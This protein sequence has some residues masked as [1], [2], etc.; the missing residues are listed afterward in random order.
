VTLLDTASGDSAN[1]VNPI[2]VGNIGGGSGGV[3]FDGAG[4]LY[5][6]NGYQ[7]AGPSPTGAIKV[8]ENASWWAALSGGPPADFEA[9]G[10][11]VAELLSAGS[12]GFDA[13]GNLHVGGG[14]SA[15]GDVDYIGLIRAQVVSNALAGGGPA[16][17][18]DPEQV[19]RFDPDAAGTNFYDAGYNRVRNELYV[20]DGATV[21]VYAVPEPGSLVLL[22]LGGLLGWRR[23]CP[24]PRSEP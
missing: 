17:P 13:E 20:R 15:A 8:F 7:L 4:N 11:G 3:A 22:A 12:L 2:V 18:S 16:D 24:R 23:R 10:T 21:F 14:D 9:G 5:T 6:G 1:P 19:G